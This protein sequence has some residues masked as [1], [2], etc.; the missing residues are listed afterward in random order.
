MSLP[1][2]RNKQDPQC[3]SHTD[4][5]ISVWQPIK[6]SHSQM[7][8]KNS[9]FLLLES[10][11]FILGYEK[12]I[13]AQKSLCFQWASMPSLGLSTLAHPRPTPSSCNFYISS[14]QYIDRI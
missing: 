9:S 8:M 5:L 14:T 6:T 7:I 2:Q 13:V 10:N 12:P 3:F 1:E 4:H 11:F